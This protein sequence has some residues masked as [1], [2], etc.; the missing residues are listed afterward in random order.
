MDFLYVCTGLIPL[1]PL[2]Y[3]TIWSHAFSGT[4]PSNGGCT[5]GAS[6]DG[7]VTTDCGQGTALLDC[8]SNFNEGNFSDLSDTPIF[9]WNKTASLSQQV[10]MVFKFDQQ[11]SLGVIRMFFWTSL[12]DEIIV[13]NVNVYWSDNSTISNE[14]TTTRGT[15]GNGTIGQH[16]LNIY[17]SHHELKFRYVRITMSFG[18][19]C[20]WIFLSEVEFCGE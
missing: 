17:I 10:F 20:E 13:P 19:T 5:D 14:F 9:I 7:Q 2:S 3:N 11:I 1:S 6:V 15:S 4:Q 16:I 18:D 12:S 8:D